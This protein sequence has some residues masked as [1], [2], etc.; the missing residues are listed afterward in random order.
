MSEITKTI[1]TLTGVVTSDKMDKSITVSVERRLQDT[2]YGTFIRRSTNLHVNDDTNT[3]RKGDKVRI[4][5]CR[6]RSKTKTWELVEVI[7]RAVG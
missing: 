4:K 7:E 6:P 3:C 2:V 1:R 5:E